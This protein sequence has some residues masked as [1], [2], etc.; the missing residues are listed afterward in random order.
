MIAGAYDNG[1]MI[2]NQAVN[3]D[4]A[5]GTFSMLL[6]EVTD[7][8]IRIFLIDPMTYAPLTEMVL[9]TER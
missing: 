6:P 8:E 7:S 9:L 1:K 4:L 5:D 2:Q 3:I